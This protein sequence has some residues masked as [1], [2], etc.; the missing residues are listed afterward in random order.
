M[1]SATFLFQILGCLRLVHVGTARMMPLALRG[2]NLEFGSFPLV[3]V[4]NRMDDLLA[5]LSPRRFCCYIIVRG[6]TVMRDL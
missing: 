3:S 6:I 2:V 5:K 4:Q 1:F